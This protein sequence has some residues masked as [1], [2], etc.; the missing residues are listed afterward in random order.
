MRPVE[1]SNGKN[2]L[3]VTRVAPGINSLARDDFDGDDSIPMAEVASYM[4]VYFNGG[5]DGNSSL[6]VPDVNKDLLDP[7]MARDGTQRVW[8]ED[9]RTG[10]LMPTKMRYGSATGNDDD[11]EDN[12]AN[13]GEDGEDSILLLP[14]PLGKRGSDDDA[15]TEKD[16]ESLEQ[17]DSSGH[18]YAAMFLGA[19]FVCFQGMLA[20]FSFI[21]AALMTLDETTFVKV[22]SSI[23]NDFRRINFLLSSLASLG[24]LDTV[25]SLAARQS[26][27]FLSSSDVAGGFGPQLV[28]REIRYSYSVAMLSALMYFIT[29]V[30]TLILSS[31]DTI[32]YYKFGYSG[33]DVTDGS[34]V[35][36][37]LASSDNQSRIDQ[38]KTLVPIRIAT[39]VIGWVANCFIIWRE[40]LAKDGRGHELNRLMAV[41]GAWKQR[42]G[43]L[44]GEAIEE[45]DASELRK[46]MAL[47]A[48][49]YERSSAAMKV[50]D[51]E[52]YY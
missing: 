52:S 9:A 4:R 40:M 27:P 46:L 1:I 8:V 47:Q 5:F 7:E 14:A 3:P 30:L 2:A 37:A 21:S 23:S 39:A 6:T 32:I 11:N 45:L 26:R 50:V 51:K 18:S 42:V 20:G 22:Y 49:G 44:E 33:T 13:E 29:L 36:A 10:E 17:G 41:I 24:A 43:E 31:T 12:L 28:L 35:A 25:F 19:I 38:W 15:T 16:T 34:W 48:L